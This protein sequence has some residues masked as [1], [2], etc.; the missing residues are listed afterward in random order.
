MAATHVSRNCNAFRVLFSS[1]FHRDLRRRMATMPTGRAADPAVHSVEPEVIE[2]VD[3]IKEH[4]LNPKGSETE[5]QPSGG[6]GSVP[7]SPSKPPLPSSPKLE[8]VGVNTPCNPTTQQKRRFQAEKA[9]CASLELPEERKEERRKQRKEQE[10]DDKKYFESRKASPL[11]EIEIADT[12]KP[13]TQA[14]DGTAND[15][16]SGEGA[17]VMFSDEQMDTEVDSLTRAAEMWNKARESGD[18]DSPHGRILR[19]LRGEY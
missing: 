15:G 19:E 6:G 14:S 8:S 2:A 18:P 1:Y 17:V 13:I 10:E 3:A 5:Y 16:S 9:I 11:S 7:L 12:R 4:G